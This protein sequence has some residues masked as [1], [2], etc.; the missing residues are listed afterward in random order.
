MPASSADEREPPED[1]RYK[2]RP[3]DEGSIDFLRATAKDVFNDKRTLEQIFKDNAVIRAVWAG[4]VKARAPA[5]KVLAVHR[6]TIVASGKPRCI[7]SRP[8]F[9]LRKSGTQNR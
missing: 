3:D 7:R 1:Q 2:H 8:Y 6:G 4:D 5:R 9:L